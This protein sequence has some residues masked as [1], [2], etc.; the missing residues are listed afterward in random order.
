MAAG[1]Q[2]CNKD[3]PTA[4]RHSKASS[5]SSSAP[6]SSI[7]F[8]RASICWAITPFVAG[9]LSAHTKCR[10]FA[11]RLYGVLVRACG[12][13]R[14]VWEPGLSGA[15]RRRTRGGEQA[16]LRHFRALWFLRG[17]PQPPQESVWRPSGMW[18]SLVE[19]AGE[20]G[21][22]CAGPQSLFTMVQT[23]WPSAMMTF[24][25]AVRLTTNVSA[26]STSA[27]PVTLTVN[28]LVTTPAANVTVAVLAV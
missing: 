23:A 16:G 27:S 20:P 26:G 2:R 18:F 13:V 11:V 6:C 3:A 19:R 12:E 21:A 7:C 28:V 24:V 8:A 9:P 15:G 25:G 17:G 10:G 1:A 22:P 14:N 4:V 5:L